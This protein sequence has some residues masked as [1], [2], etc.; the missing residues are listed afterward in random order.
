MIRELTKVVYL[1]QNGETQTFL[2]DELKCVNGKQFVL[3]GKLDGVRQTFTLEDFLYLDE[4][5]EM[6][7]QLGKS[8]SREIA[9][10]DKAF[11]LACQEIV[12]HVGNCP[13]DAKNLEFPPEEW[14]DEHCYDGERNPLMCWDV[15]MLK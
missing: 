9:I 5:V 10:R 2:F 13:Y 4:A 3:S 14:C 1:D 8:S 6:Y 15:Y 7:I 11:K 12:D